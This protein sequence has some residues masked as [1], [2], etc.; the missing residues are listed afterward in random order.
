MAVGTVIAAERD[1]DATR[2]RVE[3]LRRR[4]LFISFCRGALPAVMAIVVLGLA[5]AAGVK[6][7]ADLQP[8]NRS[9]GE[10]R[11]IGPEFHGHDKAGRPYLVTAESAVRDPAHPEISVMTRPKLVMQ[12]ENRGE[13]TVI[14]PHGVYDET[15]K[16][17]DLSGGVI[18]TDGLGNRFTSPNA[19][20]VSDA[21]TVSGRDGVTASGPLGRTSGSSYAID[22]KAGHAVLNG[23]VHTHL[24]SRSNRP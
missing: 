21:H 16:I 2:L 5:I 20:V 11:M 13:V 10:I 9:A 17:T 19:H 23:N 7:F 18:A 3:Q 24:V 15:R 12:T 4:S 14:A 22:D 6:T 8:A 1:P